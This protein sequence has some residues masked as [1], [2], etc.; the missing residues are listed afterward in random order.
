[1]CACRGKQNLWAFAIRRCLQ[2]KNRTR[3]AEHHRSRTIPAEA[4]RNKNLIPKIEIESWQVKFPIFAK[5]ENNIHDECS[6]YFL[7]RD[8]MTTADRK[9]ILDHF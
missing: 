4:T 7:A 9:T 6:H 8:Y 2:N 5:T 1:M 3:V